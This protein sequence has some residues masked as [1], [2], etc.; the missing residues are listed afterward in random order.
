MVTE[1]VKRPEFYSPV[2]SRTKDDK[3]GMLIGVLLPHA[4]K[5]RELGDAL[6]KRAMLKVGQ[7][8]ADEAWADLIACHRLARHIAKGGTL[9]ELLV[10]IALDAIASK[11]E[12]A[13]I[14]HVKPDAKGA[15]AC[16]KDL[17]G[18]TPMALV[19]D[20]MNYTERFTLLD[21]LC[22]MRRNGIEIL[23]GLANF[24]EIDDNAKGNA[25]NKA[26][27]GI[28]WSPAFKVCTSY[29]DRLIAITVES[30][31]PTRK[32]KWA[33]FEAELK[34]MKKGVE[35]SHGELKKKIVAGKVDAFVTQKIGVIVLSMLLPASNKVCEARDRSQMTIDTL[36]LA[37]ALAAYRD[38]HKQYPA[39]LAVLASKYVATVPI[40]VI[41][42]KPLI[43]KP[44]AEG[45]VLYSVGTNEID[46]G[47]RLLWDKYQDGETRGDDVGVRMPPRKK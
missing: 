21:I 6:V 24:P 16:L 18:L 23:E 10:G 28:D 43:Y 12:V 42:G 40:D 29:Y 45:Y 27:A 34:K 31:R 39:S 33:A 5:S 11:A 32:A 38:E 17:D 25:F 15:M 35:D 41:T 2:I 9:I 19:Q 20:K 22:H 4:Q 13:F 36:R 44:S 46:D 3:P 1:A 30:D 37:F 47:G 14:E 8:K 26:L 7:G